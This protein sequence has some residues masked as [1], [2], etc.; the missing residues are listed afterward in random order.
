[1]SKISDNEARYHQETIDSMSQRGAEK[2][3]FVSSWAY[4]DDPKRLAFTF[5]RY[6]F[7]AKMLGGCKNVIEIGCGDAFF[8]RVVRQDVE[9]LTAIDFDKSFIEDA[10]S[11]NCDKWPIDLRVHDIIDGPINEKFDGA[12]SL[13]VLEHIESDQ[14]RLFIKNICSS[15]VTNGTLIIGMPS[16][17]SQ[18]YAS[19]HSKIGH[20]NCKDQKDLKALL[21][22]FFNNV[23]MFS[24][25]DEVVHTGYHA[26][27]HYNLAIC[28]SKRN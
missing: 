5:S 3:G 11:R 10:K 16:I 27:S 17:Q 7:V 6:K 20:I 23:Y 28:C 8:S 26:M 18:L 1:M 12:Y 9:K 19:A 25:N 24:M 22:E 2:M 4:L 21:L 13:D 14:E 15:L